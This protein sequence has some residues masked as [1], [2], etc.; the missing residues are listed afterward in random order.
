MLFGSVVKTFTRPVAVPSG[1][2][3]MVGWVFLFYRVYHSKHEI[4]KFEI[5]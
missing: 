5:G 1:P 4:G 2:D 3:P